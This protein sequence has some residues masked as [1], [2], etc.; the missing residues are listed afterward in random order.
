MHPRISYHHFIGF[1]CSF[2][3]YF[4][5]KHAFFLRSCMCVHLR[6][7]SKKFERKN[8]SAFIHIDS[9]R[10][11]S[12]I[13]TENAKRTEWLILHFSVCI[14]KETCRLHGKWRREYI[15]E[16]ARCR[17][18]LFSSR[19]TM[20]CKIVSHFSLCNCTATIEL[21]LN[22]NQ[23]NETHLHIKN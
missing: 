16:H 18:I 23:C 3:L 17:C 8:T 22:V 13:I 2:R 20:W 10:K 1:V 11:I 15:V 21:G 7:R 12:I 19:C 14:S 6:A 9:W 5:R 4:E